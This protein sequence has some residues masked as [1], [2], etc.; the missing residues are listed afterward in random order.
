MNELDQEEMRIIFQHLSDKLTFVQNNLEFTED[1]T[2]ECGGIYNT[3]HSLMKH[4]RNGKS[5]KSTNFFAP[6]KKFTRIESKLTSR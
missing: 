1:E 4:C 5:V 3:R 6:R 2:K